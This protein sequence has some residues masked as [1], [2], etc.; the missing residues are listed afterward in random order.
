MTEPAAPV[1][2]ELGSAL[3]GP[4]RRLRLEEWARVVG[5]LHFVESVLFECLGRAAAAGAPVGPASLAVWASGASLRASWRAGQLSRLLPISDGLPERHSVVRPP[6]G[7]EPALSGL[8]S[9]LLADMCAEV[10][11]LWHPALRW[12]YDHRARLSSPASDGP[13]ALT[14]GRLVADI[15][16]I[17]DLPEKRHDAPEL[18]Q[19]D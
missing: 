2:A 5:G 3:A 13:F 16:A 9:L 10:A 18:Q 7:V 15:D 4:L 1:V 12:A 11:S 14:L 17:L 6:G 19:A 8:T